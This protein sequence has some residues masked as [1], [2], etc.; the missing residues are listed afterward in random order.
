MSPSPTGAAWVLRTQTGR[1]A[2]EETLGCLD[3][4]EA[5]PTGDL[6][7]AVQ[8]RQLSRGVGM[9]GHRLPKWACTMM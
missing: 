9:A 5:G 8:G 3:D 2:G 4:L 1:H 6:C 7:R